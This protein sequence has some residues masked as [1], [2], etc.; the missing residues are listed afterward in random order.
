MSFIQVLC[1]CFVLCRK[2]RMVIS[3]G[4]CQ[5]SLLL[6]VGHSLKAKLK[7]VQHTFYVVFASNQLNVDLHQWFTV[8]KISLNFSNI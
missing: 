7:M 5:G 3:T 4:L 6:S 1:S 2:S 8:H